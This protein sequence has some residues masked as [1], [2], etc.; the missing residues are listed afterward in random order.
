[1]RYLAP[2]VLDSAFVELQVYRKRER[3]G[4]GERGEG[5]RE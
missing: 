5:E 4:R 2:E 3:E 1:M